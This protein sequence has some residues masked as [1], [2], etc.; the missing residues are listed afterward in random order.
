M[1]TDFDR[2]VDIDELQ[3]AKFDAMDK[4]GDGVLSWKE[5]REKGKFHGAK[6]RDAQATQARRGRQNKKNPPHVVGSIRRET[7]SCNLR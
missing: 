5:L 3:D 2:F 7:T 4:N 6:K 1:D